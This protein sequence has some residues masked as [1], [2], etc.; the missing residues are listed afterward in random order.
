MLTDAHKKAFLHNNGAFC[1]QCYEF[2]LDSTETIFPPHD[3]N[4][5]DV[6]YQCKACQCEITAHYKLFDVTIK[7]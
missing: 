2:N 3:K 5:V 4:I 7:P 6:K 1:P